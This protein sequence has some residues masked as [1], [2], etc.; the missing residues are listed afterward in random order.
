[1]KGPISEHGHGCGSLVT[2]PA[3]A[4]LPR[5]VAW[6]LTTEG[7][8]LRKT[9]ATLQIVVAFGLIL[10]T[11]MLDGSLSTRPDPARAAVADRH[12]SASVS[13]H[14]SP[15]AKRKQERRHDR[16]RDRAR[17]R[18]RDRRQADNAR[19][20]QRHDRKRKRTSNDIGRLCE[21]QIA[22]HRGGPCTHG[23]D[24]APP[25]FA[26]TQ[27]VAP[28]APAATTGPAS[29]IAC[30]GDGQSGFRLQL[31]YVHAS[32]VPSRY[33]EYRAS[34]QTWAAEADEI[35]ATSAQETGGAR[36]IRF[37][38]D[39][40]CQPIVTEVTLSPDGDSNFW[41]TVGELQALGYARGDRLYQAFVDANVY[42][43]VGMIWHDDRADGAHNRHNVGPGFSR[44]DSGCW[45]G[46]I[47]AHELLHNLGGVQLSAPNSSG[48]FHCLDEYDVLCYA[49][50][51]QSG[52]VTIAC[53]D[54]ANDGLLLDC[55]HDDYFSTDPGPGSYLASHW[56]TANNRFLIGAQMTPASSP[57][58]STT[59]P[60]STQRDKRDKRAKS[61]KKNKKGKG[62]KNKGKKGHGAARHR[63]HERTVIRG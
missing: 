14:P 28:L 2:S 15:R 52:E 22:A 3:G 35:V 37:V 21:D 16:H 27:D 11:A 50:G 61:K 20:R 12:D 42:C 18:K 59:S 1:M 49:D 29:A 58:V 63:S 8:P 40:Q 5:R 10:S 45:G 4:K 46:M 25:G 32:D 34:I 24:P 9:V 30:E 53:A 36:R 31:L 60:L 55:N 7:S 13:A 57:P 6:S 19:D 38:H 23:P 48:G 47:A 44:V 43:G 17:E 41:T 26:V 62:G 39:A 56:N 33:E 51:A 54:P